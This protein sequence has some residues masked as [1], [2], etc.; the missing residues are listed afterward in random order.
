MG[1]PAESATRFRNKRNQ[2]EDDLRENEGERK[3]E[4]KGKSNR[5]C[6]LSAK[7]DARHSYL[8]DTGWLLRRHYLL[9]GGPVVI[10]KVV[11]V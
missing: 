3:D 7:P 1:P 4:E 2:A 6:M 9:G 8:T 5:I 11:I 10:L